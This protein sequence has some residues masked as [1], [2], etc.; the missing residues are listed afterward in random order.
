M[1]AR[2]VLLLSSFS[3]L[4]E[5]TCRSLIILCWSLSICWTKSGLACES[6]DSVP[7]AGVLAK[8]LPPFG[9]VAKKV[10]RVG[11]AGSLARVGDALNLAFSSAT[12]FTRA[13]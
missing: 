3:L 4:M 2:R 12:E 6:A 13:S 9:D 1:A 5:A 8:G 11:P 10:G 7:G